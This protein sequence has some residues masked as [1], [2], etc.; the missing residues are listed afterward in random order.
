[1][2]D[3]S[4]GNRDATDREGGE[5]I[6]RMLLISDFE[7]EH[8]FLRVAAGHRLIEGQGIGWDEVTPAAVEEVD[9][10]VLDLAHLPDTFEKPDCLDPLPCLLLTPSRRGRFAER[11]LRLGADD[12]LVAGETDGERIH[13]QFTYA[14]ERNRLAGETRVAEPDGLASSEVLCS[15]YGLLETVE[16]GVVIADETGKFRYWNPTAQ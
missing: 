5:R 15:L 9:V 10:V 8:P 11:M 3:L 7:G 14:I 12:Y 16:E 1:M 2:T 4:L 6:V 13:A